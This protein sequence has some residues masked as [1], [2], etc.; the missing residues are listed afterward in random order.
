MAEP[1]WERIGF[2]VDVAAD[3]AAAG[4][5]QA[6]PGKWVNRLAVPGGWIYEV[7][8]QRMVGQE[9]DRNLVFVPARQAPPPPKP[10]PKPAP[11]S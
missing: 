7:I 8:T 11:K 3:F 4:I 2:S 10:K 6:R 9:V 1:Q 5:Q